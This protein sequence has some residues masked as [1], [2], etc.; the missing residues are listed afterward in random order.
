M[1]KEI[2]DHAQ[3]KKI[4]EPRLHFSRLGS[5][6]A[7]LRILFVVLVLLPALA[8]SII[9]GL[10]SFQGGKQQAIDQLESVATLKESEINRWLQALQLDLVVE[11]DREAAQQR[12]SVL[13]QE[14]PDP[15]EFQA[16]YDAQLDRFR[17]SIEVQQTFEELFLMNAE[18]KAVLST[19]AD[20]RY[21]LHDKLSYFQRGLEGP[22]AQPPFYSPSLGKVSVIVARP[23]NNDQG[24]PIGVLAGRASMT[25]LSEIMS[26]RAGLGNTG[27]TYLVGA[28][29]ALLTELRS[30]Q[31]IGY[32]RSSG[33]AK[34]I[35]NRAN[36]SGLYS[37]YRGRDIVGV[38]HW[39]P[40]LQIALLAEQEQSEAF[41]STFKALQSS[42]V[43]AA[44]A[45]MVALAAAMRESRN[46]AN[47][48]THLVETTSQIA[49]GDLSARARITSRDEIGAL[50]GSFNSMA[51]RVSDLLKGLETRSRELEERTRE[52]E[53]SQRVTSAASERVSPDELLD[54]VVNLIRDQFNLYHAQ[55]YIVDAEQQAAVLRESTGYAGRQLL[56]RGHKI[57]LDRPALVTRCIT[58]G[59][60]VLVDDVSQAEDWLPNPLL[61]DTKS[62]LVVPLIVGD[63]VIGVLDAQD[64][65]PGRFTASTVAL[66]QTMAGEIGFL[67]ENSELLQRITEQ[68]Q[69]LTIFTTQLRTA[70]D[71]ARQLGSVLDPERLLQQVVELLQ[72]RFGLYHA[73]IYVLDEAAGQLTLQAGSGEVGRVLRERGHSIPLDRE[74]SLVARAA[75]S[76]T[77]VLVND[78]SLESDFMPNPLLP[79]TR[80]E[81]AVPLI[82]GD[83][84][85]GVLDVQDDQSDRFTEAD[86]DTFN[87]LAGQVATA[88]Q[89]AALFEEQRKAETK[90]RTVA[91]F[92]HAW[93]TW[94][95]PDGQYIYV[96][97]A[98][99][100]ITGYTVQEFVAHPALFVDTAHP[101]DR[102]IVDAHVRDH[103]ST[104]DTAPIEY[105]I[106]TKDGQVRWV[107]HTCQAV[108]DA[109]GNWQGRRG[110]NRDITIEKQAEAERERFT[111]QLRTAADLAEQI[112]A[113]LDPEQLLPEVVN[114]LRS[115]FNLY[116]VHI[117]LLD[118]PAEALLREA[119]LEQVS[120]MMHDRQLM[121]RAGSGEVG[122]Q[123]LER[124]H[125][126][127]LA[128]EQSLVARAARTRQ[129]V[130]VADTTSAPDFMPN[131][132]LPETRS[133][134]AVPLVAGD[135]VLG[136]LDVQDNQ[137]D[138]FSQSD[139]NILST[140]AGQIA[141]ALQNAAFVKE[142]QQ[143]TER[144]REVDR[145]KSEFLASMSHELRTPLNSII[146]FAEVLL[147]GISGELPPDTLEDVQAIYDN[148]QHLLR[149]INDVLDLAKIEAGTLA[150]NPEPIQVTPLLEEVKTNNAGLLVNKPVEMVIE[151]E[152]DLPEIQVDPLRLNQILNNLVSNAVKFTEKGT[153]TLSAFCDDGWLCITVQDTGIGIRESDLD[154]IF[155]RFRQ[156][157]GSS[158]RRAEGTGLGLAITRHLVHMHGGSVSVHSQ[159]GQGS[160]FTVRLPLQRPAAG[161]KASN[162]AQNDDSHPVQVPL[163]RVRDE[164]PTEKVSSKQSLGAI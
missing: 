85:V 74:R 30:D 158:A 33:A 163:S 111:T 89:N 45:I 145:L 8:I 95:G 9:S 60:P 79:Q 26:E 19:D 120:R 18:G 3:E 2:N 47:P 94:L 143:T 142:I 160:T 32:V 149:I 20:Q 125:S 138:R 108:Y 27:E 55:V 52:L 139:L 76:K 115:R 103:R 99:E 93:E 38:Y 123:L 90:F 56:Q 51:E 117:Y 112:N 161:Q 4:I 101:D 98:C 119:D 135:K 110:S 126:I 16:A 137:P 148:G 133:E 12:L 150:L 15:G 23:V 84:T 36:G 81:L 13:L 107:G 72:S 17:Q 97:P 151:T 96:S 114:E 141:I 35:N 14:S 29:A 88:L 105:R 62:E 92:T 1:K 44:I 24:Q 128:R 22:Y 57:P 136:V 91:D 31:E 80:S 7:R 34:A 65:T 21:K 39:M 144:L 43:V 46:I 87:T 78:T 109:E 53:A 129:I 152:T 67:F 48:L 131:P 61:P 71:I 25:R 73:H 54:L 118:E 134:V 66:F 83:K 159:V 102:A 154:K 162:D 69:A 140:L 100:R 41:D 116:H 121:I 37:N 68:T 127:P 147:M 86:R 106:I 155:E 156:A 59:Q 40:E 122:R 42:A 130:A 28:N 63:K 146:G 50:A 6:R 5:I 11:L 75:R 70:A 64:R 49:G 164:R 82:Y 132:L 157:D 104:A 113:I 153:I 58:A 124:G 77:T 10:Q